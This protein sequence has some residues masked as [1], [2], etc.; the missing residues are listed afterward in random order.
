LPCT[1]HIELGKS[2]IGISA[3]NRKQ[4]KRVAHYFEYTDCIMLVFALLG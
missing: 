4:G 1:D 2:A 3:F